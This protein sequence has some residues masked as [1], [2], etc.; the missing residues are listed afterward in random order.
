[1]R[2]LVKRKELSCWVSSIIVSLILF[3]NLVIGSAKYIM[4]VYALMFVASFYCIMISIRNFK[5]TNKAIISVPFFWIIS[6]GLLMFLYGYFGKFP[7]EYSLNFHLLNMYSII[8][9]LIILNHKRDSVIDVVA[10]AGGITIILMSAFIFLSA[11]LNLRALFG[12]GMGR[13]GY[14]A[15]GN[16]NTTA[17]SYIVLL[18]PIVYLILIEKRWRYI[19]VA[20]IALVFMFI[21]GSKKTIISIMI[22]VFVCTLEKSKNKR[23]Y[24]INLLKAIL[25]MVLVLLVCYFI[26]SLNK[27]IWSRLVTMIEVL[28]NFNMGDQSS[29]GLRM[30]YIITA[31]TKAWDKPLFGHGWGSFKNMYGYSSLYKTELYTHCNYA[32]ILFS[33]GILGVIVFYFLPFYIVKIWR[34]NRKSNNSILV[35]LYFSCLL[36]IDLGTV[37]SYSS[38]LGY[39]GFSIA[40]LLER[41]NLN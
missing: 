15:V 31:F 22:M 32:E 40:Y 26:P 41:N 23:Q 6:C 27:M 28:D 2:I 4:Y 36:F 7:E 8:L 38:I 19:P 20:V 14:T 34:K 5:Y 13:I 39:I 18:I 1:M 30:G 35:A 24:I 25:L 9:T 10:R 3:A 12:A 11:G 37:T 29:T 21:T 17:V 16:V 33:F